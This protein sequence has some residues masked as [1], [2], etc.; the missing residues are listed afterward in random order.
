VPP[1]SIANN[2]FKAPAISN[3]HCRDED[4]NRAIVSQAACARDSVV[5]ELDESLLRETL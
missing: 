2:K 3:F 1:A 5:F 4:V